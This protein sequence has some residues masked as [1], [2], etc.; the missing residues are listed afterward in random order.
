M[1][2]SSRVWIQNKYK[3]LWSSAVL[4]WA[5]NDNYHSFETNGLLSG[6]QEESLYCYSFLKKEIQN[7][8]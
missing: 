5:R 3:L 2:F 8:Y 7:H 1:L 4:E 6:W